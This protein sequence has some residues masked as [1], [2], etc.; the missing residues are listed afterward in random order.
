MK[1]RK[2]ILKVTAMLLATLVVG[3]LLGAMILGAVLRN[4]LEVLQDLRT[5]DGFTS[6]VSRLIGPVDAAEATEVRA[7]LEA[8]GR[9]V[10]S[11]MDYQQEE[12]QILLDGMEAE[13]AHR[14][15]PEQMQRWYDVR[16]RIR[17]RLDRKRGT[18][19]DNNPAPDVSEPENNGE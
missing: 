1:T 12:F 13:L 7:I 15:T 4:R 11:L 9:E 10:E 6:H 8:T 5:A 16:A 19:P 2:P 17:K 3:M 14:L 18:A